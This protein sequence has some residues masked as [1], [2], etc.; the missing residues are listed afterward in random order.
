QMKLQNLVPGLD[1]PGALTNG[2]LGQI[3]R[4]KPGPGE[5]QEPKS[6]DQNKQQ[7]GTLKDLFDVF[8]KKQ[9]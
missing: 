2:I 8:K 9:Q 4:G 6:Q 1:N 7:P 3:L 5:Q